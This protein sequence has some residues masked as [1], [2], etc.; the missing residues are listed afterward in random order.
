MQIRQ[1]KNTCKLCDGKGLYFEITKSGSKRWIYRYKIDGKESTFTIGHYPDLSLEKARSDHAEAYRLVK[2]GINPS[3]NRRNNKQANIKKEEV[4]RKSS[5]NSFENVA[6][7]WINQ[8][9][10][11]WSK[12]HTQSVLHTL[13]NDVFNKIGNKP[14][15]IITPPEVLEILRKIERR[16]SLEIARKVL[17]RM[18]AVFR[19]AVQTGMATYNPA[20]EMR[21]VL[22][23]RQVKHM[24]AVYDNDLA[25][26]LKDIALRQGYEKLQHRTFP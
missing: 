17:Q 13:Q 1:A 8:Q 7:D 14:V 24:P 23:T 5:L 2:Q 20:A 18:T 11:A 19:Y 3:K 12:G 15:D 9:K 10:G 21:G 25:R 26:L 6:L 4:E 16:G 22:K